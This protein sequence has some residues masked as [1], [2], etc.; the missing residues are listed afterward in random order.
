MI[1]AR[2]PDDPAS[3]YRSLYEVNP[4]ALVCVGFESAYMGFTVG[5]HP[6]AVYDYEMCID[7]VLGEGDITRDEAVA[8]FYFYTLSECVLEDSPIFIRMP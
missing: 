7:A 6:V 1:T 2:N 4:D 5:N 8:Y 3:L